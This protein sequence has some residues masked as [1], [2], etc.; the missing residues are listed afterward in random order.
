MGVDE[1]FTADPVSSTARQDTEVRGGGKLYQMRS[2]WSPG[3]GAPQ[4][5]GTP[6]A[7]L[8]EG[9][10]PWGTC[11]HLG[12]R[13]GPQVH[14]IVGGDWRGVILMGGQTWLVD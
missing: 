4:Y 1:L 8:T 13:W 14:Q 11:G 3:F 2:Q 6:G 7:R 5:V 9:G 10:A 12:G